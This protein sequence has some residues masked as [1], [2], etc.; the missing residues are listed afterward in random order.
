MLIHPLLY[1]YKALLS[2]GAKTVCDIGGFGGV[3]PIVMKKLGFDMVMTE[4]LKYYSAAFT[5]LFDA[6]RNAGVTI[7]DYD[8]FED[9]PGFPD[10]FDAVTC[11]AVLEH[12]PHSPH[13]FMSNLESLVKPSGAIYLE[14][15][16]IAYW[17]KRAVMLLGKSPLPDIS[18]IYSSA[19]PF[20]GHHHEYTMVELKKLASLSALEVKAEYAFNYS[21]PFPRTPANHVKLWLTEPI[22]TVGCYV[23]PNAM[24]II[25][26]LCTPKG[27]AA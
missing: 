11:M 21:K 9:R 4:A 7:I 1:R 27:T 14:V 10:R 16:N 3:F 19:V 15:P 25:S 20:I 23:L 13:F 5:P 12:Y 2:H 18:E 26:V 8:P 17:P 6:V 22:R 24:E